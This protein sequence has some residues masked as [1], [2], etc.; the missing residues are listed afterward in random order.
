MSKGVTMKFSAHKILRLA[1]VVLIAGAVQIGIASS[2]F[3]GTS[4]DLSIELHPAAQDRAFAA[5]VC[6]NGTDNV[7]GFVFDV[8]FVNYS[9]TESLALPPSFVGSNPTDQGT[10]DG[11]TNT[12][13]GVIEPT[14]CVAIGFVGD[15]TGELGETIDVTVSIVSS[16][17]GDST[18]NVDPTPGN[19]TDTYSTAPI[20]AD[21]DLALSTRLLTTGE[22]GSGDTVEYELTITNQGEG[23]YVENPTAPLGVYFIIPEGTTFVGIT[24]V[25]TDDNYSLV[26]GTCG[27]MG[28]ASAFVPAF[29][30]F[31]AELAGCQL[32]SSTD[33]I[34]AGASFK[35]IYTMTASGPFSTGATEV[36]AIAVADDADSIALQVYMFTPGS[37]PFA[38]ESNNTNVLTYD[39]NE[40]TVTVNRCAGVGEV[41]NTDDACFT[42]TFNKAIYEPDFTQ[43]DL[44]LT[45]GGTIYEFEKTGTN[46]WTVRINGMTPGGTVA[47]SLEEAGVQDLSAVQNGASVLG[48]NT[49]RYEVADPS[50]DTDTDTDGSAAA[51]DTTSASGTLAATGASDLIWQF[52]L[53]MV[54][55]G[56][57][58]VLAAARTRKA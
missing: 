39:G 46:E 57:A 56:A 50:S 40:L 28:E 4:G 27:S 9:V 32:S 7:I 16:T 24:D 2:A 8:D 18:P 23:D 11:N 36:L 31:N 51:T 35:L 58:L 30:D 41:V 44:V 6:N 29:A 55:L 49:V 10:Y 15:V 38:F 33:S 52:A 1:M 19:D 37:D 26:D 5:L 25:D 3:A 53:V 45:G 14:Q 13:E 43:D 48:V 47:L 54:L 20:V 34:P 21:A 22:I 12:W 42:V 17:L